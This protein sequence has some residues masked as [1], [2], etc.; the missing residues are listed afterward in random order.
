VKEIDEFTVSGDQRM[1]TVA[2]AGELLELPAHESAGEQPP[3]PQA[4]RFN[5]ISNPAMPSPPNE[6]ADMDDQLIGS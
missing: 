1:G 3:R 5:E 2:D 6:D 4:E